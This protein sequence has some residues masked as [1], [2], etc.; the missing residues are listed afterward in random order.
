MMGF[1]DLIDAIGGVRVRIEE[2]I[3]Y[4]VHGGVLE[5]G[6]R[7]LNG[8]D[9]LWYGRS[10][11]N[12]DDYGRMGRQGCLI[13]YVT[14]Q[15]EPTTIL[16]SYRRLAGATERTLSTDIP[17]PKVPAFIELADLV[18]DDGRMSTL[19]LS[20]PQVNTA[21]PDWEAIR[22]LV[23]RAID[24]SGGVGDDLVGTDDG[25]PEPSAAD[26]SESEDGP[27]EE[28]WSEEDDGRTEWQRYTGL[29][30]E[31]PADPGRQVGEE[32]TDLNALCP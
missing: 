14:E 25:A 11:T 5:P 23:S 17:Q 7:R 9:A 2:P 8:H 29:E 18:T 28:T 4:G 22:D 30:Q 15:V 1:R 10:R 24:V 3:P 31:E 20:P 12:S 6:V 13:K 27:V 21:N 16:T 19:Q 26:S 32:A